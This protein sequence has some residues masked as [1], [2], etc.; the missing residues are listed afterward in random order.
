M[1]SSR[2]HAHKLVLTGLP[3]YLKDVLSCWVISEKH[4]KQQTSAKGNCRSWWNLPLA[5]TFKISLNE[6]I[7]LP[8]IF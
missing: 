6:T 8:Y 7:Y 5:I 4:I 1:M 3:D 2:T